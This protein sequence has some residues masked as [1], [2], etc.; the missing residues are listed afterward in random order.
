MIFIKALRWFICLLLGSIAITASAANI[1]QVRRHAPDWDLAKPMNGLTFERAKAIKE[2]TKDRTTMLF[3]HLKGIKARP[4]HQHSGVSALSRLRGMAPGSINQSFQNISALTAA[5]TQYAVQCGW[6]GVPVWLLFDTGS[7]DTW[8]TKTG[9]KCSDGS[10]DSHNEAACGFSTPYIDGFSHGQIDELHFYLKY[11]SGEHISGPMGYSDV[12]CGGVSVSKQQVGLANNTY[13][14]GNNV[15]VGILGLAYPAITSAYYGDIGQEAPWNAM[16]YTPFLTN[17]ISQ[18][19]IDPVFSVALIKNST[20]GVIAWGGLPPMDW[21][22]RGYAK[23]DLIIANLIGQPETA[24]KYSFY[25]I[26]PDG[27]KWGQ[28]TDTTKYPYIVD[29]GTTMLYLP[30]PLAE[31]I[32]NSFQPRAVYLYQWGTYFAPCDAIPPHFAIIISGVEF[33]INPADLIYQDLIDPLTGYCAI[34]IASGGPGPYILGDVFL[35]NVLAV[36]DVGAAEMRF[37]SRK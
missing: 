26:V 33:W 14:H 13:W 7:S 35:Q 16:S 6:D 30:P 19:A 12:S 11:G 32:A 17:A 4:G 31:S 8:A 3:S 23:T 28:T 5:S 15:T 34:G 29:T 10:G 37:Y 24:W 27:M 9:F 21:Q 1:P 2:P 20:D 22:F 18:G 36:F 25:T